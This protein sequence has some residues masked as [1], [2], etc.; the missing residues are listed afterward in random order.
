MADYKK[1]GQVYDKTNPVEIVSEL[2]KDVADQGI[3]LLKGV[4]QTAMEQIGISPRKASRPTEMTLGKQAQSI[5]IQTQKAEAKVA[6]LES[7]FH[8]NVVQNTQE[9]YNFNK[10][11]EMQKM[12][13]LV[14]NLAVEVKNIQAQAASLSGDVRKV[15]VEQVPTP[16]K[17]HLNFFEWVLAMLKDIKKDIVKSRTW[18]QAFNNKKKKKGYWSMFKK[19]GTSFAMSDERGIATAAG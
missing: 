4:G 3:D 8:K 18:L 5:E 10:Q 1:K 17:Y 9:V 6:N 16:D 11:Q 2:G 12:Q 15:T 19:H 7:Q 13:A 14:Q